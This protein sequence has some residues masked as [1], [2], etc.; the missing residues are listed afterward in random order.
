MSTATTSTDTN[1]I[2]DSSHT[3]KTNLSTMSKI[4][5]SVFTLLFIIASSICVGYKEWN[6]TDVSIHKVSSEYSASLSSLPPDDYGYEDFT[7]FEDIESTIEEAITSAVKTANPE[8]NLR[9][10]SSEANRIRVL[11]EENN[12]VLNYR[13]FRTNLKLD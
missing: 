12:D 8:H 13:L 5:L 1:N 10:K 6:S 4:L 7:D 3:T 11:E 2:T 9:H